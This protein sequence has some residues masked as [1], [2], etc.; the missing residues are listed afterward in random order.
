MNIKNYKEY[1]RKLKSAKY[2]NRD[3]TTRREKEVEKEV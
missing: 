1:P 3:K 2:Q